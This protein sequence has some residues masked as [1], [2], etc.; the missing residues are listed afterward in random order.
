MELDGAAADRLRP[1]LQAGVDRLRRDGLDHVAARAAGDVEAVLRAA[2]EWRAGGR[3]REDSKVDGSP[4]ARARS[5]VAGVLRRLPDPTNGVVPARRVVTVGEAA[6][7][8]ALTS[9]HVRRL[10]ASGGLGASRKV[11]NTWLIDA[12]AV[13]ER[14]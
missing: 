14:G 8:L 10:A 3:P 2:M 6:S 4:S 12:R 7:R 13:E 9:R 11:G 5:G 1:V